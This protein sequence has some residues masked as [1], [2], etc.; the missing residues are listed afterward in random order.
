MLKNL[1]FIATGIMIIAFLYYIGIKSHELYY[2]AIL[3]PH[4]IKT[5]EEVM[6]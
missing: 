2:H 6:K 5:I 3:K 4:V 1:S